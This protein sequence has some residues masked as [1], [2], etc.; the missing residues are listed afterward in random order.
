MAIVSGDSKLEVD[1]EVDISS[2]F[3]RLRRRRLFSAS[4]WSIWS[5]ASF[6]VMRPRRM[7]WFMSVILHARSATS[8]ALVASMPV[9]RMASDEAARYASLQY[10]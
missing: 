7:P 4:I 10:S 1:V 6:G 9:S 2:P 8:L 5:R 3:L